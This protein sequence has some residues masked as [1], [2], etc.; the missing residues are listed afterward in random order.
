[1]GYWDNR[2]AGKQNLRMFEAPN[3]WRRYANEMEGDSIKVRGCAQALDAA[4]SNGLNATN[5]VVLTGAGASFS[6]K[7]PK[8]KKVAPN[9]DELWSA[10]KSKVGNT[11]FDAILA[12]IPRAASIKNI[13]KL[14]TQCKLF[15]ALYG[16]IEGAGKEIADF[17]PQAETAILERVDFV[18]ESTEL[19]AHETLLRKIA[20]RGIRKPRAKIFTT[21]Y[22]LCFEYAA[23]KRR[24]IVIDGFSH[25]APPLYDRSHFAF[26]IVRRGENEAPDYLDSVFHLYKLHGS[27]D[28]RR[29][30][31]DIIRSRD[32]GEPVLIYPRDS[33]YQEAF[34]P[35]F[36]DMMAAFQSALGEPDTTLIVAGFGF[37]DNHI[38]QPVLSA[39]ETNMTFRLIVCD[40]AFILE[41][42]LEKDPVTLDH[43]EASIKNTFHQRLVRLGKIGDQRLTLLSG[44]FEDLVDAIPD[45]VAETERERHAERVKVL[46]ETEPKKDGTGA[47]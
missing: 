33:K 45:L 34:D 6:I 37:N 10:V 27:I 18:D 41:N 40:P 28:W 8:S 11:K 42:A 31:P 12:K 15:I 44:R 26:D 16:S 7:N 17:L 24:F 9:W 3:L 2:A 38:A 23:R 14:L 30:M 43:N 47:S 21:N 32:P 1:M 19:T 20:R 39:L 22:D 5:L 46:R 25:A 4:L 29:M 13:E 36:L 35:P